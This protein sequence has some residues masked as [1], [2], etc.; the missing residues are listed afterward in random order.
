M[1]TERG[2]PKASITFLVNRLHV[3]RS[4]VDVVRELSRRMDRTEWTRERRKAAYRYAIALHRRNFATYAYVMSGGRGLE[5]I[6]S[7]LYNGG[8]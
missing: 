6:A 2:I 8:E 1:A 4:N 7:N 5:G 3:G